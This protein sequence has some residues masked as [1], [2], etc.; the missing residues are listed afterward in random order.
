MAKPKRVAV[1][2]DLHCG[3]RAGLTP[4]AHH[5]PHS[6]DKF[7]KLQVELWGLYTSKIDSIKPIDILLVNADCIDGRGEKSGS[8][9][10]IAVDRREQVKMAVEAIE[11][12]EAQNI[13][14]TYG[15]GYH[16]GNVEDWEDL[17]ADEV[18]ADKIGGHEF[19][20]VNGLIFD[21]KHKIG[22]ST[23]PHGRHTPIA[24]EKLWNIM[25]AE[26][27]NQ[28]S[29]DVII[30]S[31]VHYFDYCGD[32]RW[33]GM[34]TPALQGLGTIYGTRQCSGTVDWGFVWFDV[35][36]KD[37]YTWKAEVVEVASQRV[38]VLK[39]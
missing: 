3:H 17:I 5:R 28:P 37:N 24:K 29:S 8:R 4:K 30:R 36:S 19:I 10:L 32:A 33:L 7:H 27:E 22:S 38:S 39:F 35:L 11:Y 15:T 34:T 31:H 12:T 18:G 9:E 2:A 23:I 16:V 14:M 20:D 25:W 1:I 26:K 13:V 21:M 6:D